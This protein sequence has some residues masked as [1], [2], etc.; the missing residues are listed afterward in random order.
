[1]GNKSA[2]CKPQGAKGSSGKVQPSAPRERGMPRTGRPRQAEREQSGSVRTIEDHVAMELLPADA[3]VHDV[4]GRG[5][6]MG[7][8]GVSGDDLLLYEHGLEHRGGPG[9]TVLDRDMFR[10]RP[11]ALPPEE[12]RL[13]GL[14]LSARF[15]TE[16]GLLQFASSLQTAASSKYDRAAAATNSASLLQAGRRERAQGPEQ[17]C[18]AFP[19]LAASAVCPAVE[20]RERQSDAKDGGG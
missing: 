20:E 8:R 14:A 11:T 18:G 10:D 7:P 4:T 17:M 12:I 5:F 2:C 3:N 16:L 1:M 13:N 6:G 9:A 19:T 15:L